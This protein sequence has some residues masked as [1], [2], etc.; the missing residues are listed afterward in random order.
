M[1]I[2]ASDNE[3]QILV[4][5]Y[6]LSNEQVGFVALVL[7]TYFSNA[8]DFETTQERIMENSGLD[9]KTA[10]KIILSGGVLY[11]NRLDVIKQNEILDLLVQKEIDLVDFRAELLEM[12]ATVITQEELLTETGD[13]RNDLLNIFRDH[14][15][16]IIVSYGESREMINESVIENLFMEGASFQ[17]EVVKAL[18]A[19][20]QLVSTQPIMVNGQEVQPTIGN[21]LADFKANNLIDAS[22]AV[23]IQ[24]FNNSKN[25][26]SLSES[27]KNLITR[28][29]EIYRR[30][31]NYQQFLAKI[32]TENWHIIPPLPNEDE[33]RKKEKIDDL[34]DH[35]AEDLKWLK[36]K[37]NLTAGET[38]YQSLTVQE[39]LA[40]LDKEPQNPEVVLPVLQVLNEKDATLQSLN[41]LNL[42]SRIKNG[43]FYP[44]LKGFQDK[45]LFRQ[46]L[47]IAELAADESALFVMHL[48]G[49]NKNLMGLAYADLKENS[50][51]WR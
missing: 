2:T 8:Y 17:E 24:Y 28:L 14:F 32:D 31:E 34:K 10:E 25:F 26:R 51:K 13:D 6:N 45:P 5:K 35:Y 9:E 4:K 41:N 46:I 16:E 39:L 47:D 33:L 48:A 36:E 15:K 29:L 1:I 50:F 38:K 22:N 7:D 19:N 23:K 44:G 3:I 20:Q 37:Y 30:I 18:Q 11:F 49:I 21:W 43:E 27:D 12:E 40:V 42:V